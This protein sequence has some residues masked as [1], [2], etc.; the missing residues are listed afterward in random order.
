MN[1][2][3]NDHIWIEYHEVSSTIITCLHVLQFSA[4]GSVAMDRW[5]RLG[6]LGVGQKPLVEEAP[7][8]RHGF[9]PRMFWGDQMTVSLWDTL[10]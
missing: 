1:F 5:E 7:R 4:D 3:H 9:F 2:D 10:W 8:C 6:R